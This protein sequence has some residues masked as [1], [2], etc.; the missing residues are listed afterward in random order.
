MG[1]V[2]GRVLIPNRSFVKESF[3]DAGWHRLLGEL[4]PAHRKILDGLIVPDT[5]YDRELHGAFHR[6]ITS[7]WGAEQ[8]DL[9]RRLGIRAARHHDR[10]YLRPL[11]KLGG[12]VML[13]KRAAA[14]YREYFQ[15]GEL[16]LVESREAGGRLVLEDPEA[17]SEFCAESLVG[18]MEELIRLAGREPVRVEH[19]VC[20][21]QGA[22]HCEYEVEWR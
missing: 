4:P 10:F 7:L 18:F 11:L 3:G 15:G 6:T 12:P 2:R 8:P 13:L 16:S 1:R 9:S 21:H 19:V 14:L 20:R 17:A 22:P 5:W